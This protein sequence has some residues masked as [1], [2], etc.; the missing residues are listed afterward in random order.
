MTYERKRF[1]GVSRRSVLKASTVAVGGAG[2]TGSAAATGVT[3]QV[4]DVFG[5]GPDGPVV[6]ENG[7]MLRRTDRSLSMTLSMPTPEPGEYDY[8]EAPEGGAWTDEEGP[9]EV[10]SLWCFYFPPEQESPGR[11]WTGVYSAA[12]HVVGGPHLTLSSG[13]STGAEP[14]LGDPL[15]HPRNVPVRLAVAPHGALDPDL[16]PEALRTPTQPGP[17][18][19][20]MAEFEAE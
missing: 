10:F 5:Q 3:R 1:G 15:E 17:D 14:F 9:P 12:G 19:W 2:I 16:L 11:G 6:S 7:A 8:P 4:T 20:W 13:V 18:I